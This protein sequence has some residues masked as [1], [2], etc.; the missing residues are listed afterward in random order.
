M[1]Q[2]AHVAADG[3]EGDEAEVEQAG[4][5][6]HDVQAE[7]ADDPDDGLVDRRQRQPL[8]DQVLDLRRAGCRGRTCRTPRG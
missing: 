6:D 7:R 3:P 1:N 2:P 5:A 8:L 4:V